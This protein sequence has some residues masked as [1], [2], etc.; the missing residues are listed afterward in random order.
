MPHLTRA[1]RALGIL[2]LVPV[3]AKPP[4]AQEVIFH[5]AEGG[6]GPNERSLD[7]AIT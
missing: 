6:E 1:L 5:A 7:G 2:F 3:A 4:P